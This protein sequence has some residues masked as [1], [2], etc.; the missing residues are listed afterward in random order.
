MGNNVTQILLEADSSPV[1]DF[2][3]LLEFSNENMQKE[4][5]VSIILIYLFYDK[6]L[7]VPT[8]SVGQTW[9]YQNKCLRDAW[10]LSK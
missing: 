1:E 2:P 3:F 4:K 8:E 10:N 5:F 6:S 9:S 7:F